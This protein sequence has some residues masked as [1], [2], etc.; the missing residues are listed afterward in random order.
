VDTP[1]RCSGAGGQPNT[2]SVAELIA[3]CSGDGTAQWAPTR[4]GQAAAVS[5]AALLRR[6]GRGPHAAPGR[7][8]PRG[9][10]GLAIS[11]AD[12]PPPSRLRKAA[13]AACAM[14]AVGAVIGPSVLH[15][16][17]TP[18][19]DAEQPAQAE[20]SGYAQ[21][22]LR[23]VPKNTLRPAGVTPISL[24]VSAARVTDEPR[25]AGTRAAG[26][27]APEP[28]Q[29]RRSVPASTA[30]TPRR[31]TPPGL[32]DNPGHGAPKKALPP[33]QAKK[34]AAA[35][36]AD[37][38]SGHAEPPGQ[39]RKASASS[40]TDKSNK[41][42]KTGAAKTK[43]SAKK[44]KKAEK[45]AKSEKSKATPKETAKQASKQQKPKAHGQG[46]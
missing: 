16:T 23:R 46:N 32:V 7:L 13:V 40:S 29:G 21:G 19:A 43:Q 35:G 17:A 41:T 27:S 3:R 1:A 9:H 14:F 18:R 28:E 39:V 42:D 45:S 22:K 6:E 31:A 30:S 10:P 37:D 34:V 33:G 8:R 38:D 11:T 25:R 36:T 2:I 12:D 15:D 44:T 20:G 26:L 4:S 24:A 5:V